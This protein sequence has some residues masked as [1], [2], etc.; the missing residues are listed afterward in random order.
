MFINEQTKKWSTILTE[1]LGIKDQNKLNWMSQYATIHEIH[2]S[3]QTAGDASHGIYATPLNTIG[4]GNPAAP[5]GVG[6]GDNGIG[7]TGADF[8]NPAY[9]VGSGDALPMSTLPIALNVAAMTIGLELVPVIP[10]QG[11][12]QMLSYMD[13]PYAGGKLARFNETSLD[14]KGAGKENKPIYVKF[15]GWR[16]VYDAKT[17]DGDGRAAIKNLIPAGTA[18][19]VKADGKDAKGADTVHYLNGKY[20]GTSR[21][22]GNVI[23]EVLSCGKDAKGDDIT[24]IADVFEGSTKVV[25]YP[26]TKDDDVYLLRDITVEKTAD[27]YHDDVVVP[28]FVSTMV[29]HI[30]GFANFYDGSNDLMSRG[31]NETGVG[32]TIGARMFSKLVQM[33]SVEVTGTVTRQ[34]LQDMPLYGVD[35]IG[36]VLEAMQNELSQHINKDILTRLF[37]LGVTNAVEVYDAQGANLNLYVSADSAAATHDIPAGIMVGVDAKDHAADFGALKNAHIASAAENIT[38]F[39]RRIMSRVLA[40]SNLIAQVGRRGRANWIVTNTQVASALQDAAGFV[41]APMVNTLTQDGSQSL[42]FAG[43]LAGMNVYVD[44]YMD[45]SDTRVC[46]GRK[47]D[48]NGPG[49]IFMPYILADSIQTVAEGTMAPKLLLNSRYNVVD[50]GFFPE[51]NYFTFYVH[52]DESFV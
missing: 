39:Q 25:L 40:A 2:E 38:T 19:T 20:I 35:V 17:E 27:G 41:V 21:I 34:Q 10:A 28:D 46:V 29:D 3:L 30:P 31:Q 6:F 16:G 48:G 15:G 12:W 1:E 36:K 4:M 42:Y 18:V 7:N 51:A 14:G 22:D 24:S 44:P 11:P 8:H 33:G 45:W 49:V 5:Y 37:A 26:T 23:V 13:F 47:G 50:A 52:S 32:N 9:A 43:S